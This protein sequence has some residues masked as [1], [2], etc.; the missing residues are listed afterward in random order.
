MAE[1]IDILDGGRILYDPDFYP[2]PEADDLLVWLTSQVNWR[3]EAV[4]GNPL[5]RLNAWFAD[6]GLRY[7]YSGLSYHGAGWLPE[8]FAVKQRVEGASG[9]AFN[10]L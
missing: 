3:Q 10:S 2:R 5:P 8:L 9:A 4:R 7:S 6:D 1:W